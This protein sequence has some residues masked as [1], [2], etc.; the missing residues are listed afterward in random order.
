MTEA[1]LVPAHNAER[2][3]VMIARPAVF[4]EMTT[5]NLFAESAIMKLPMKMTDHLTPCLNQNRL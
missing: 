4:S 5:I 1:R 2:V 3:Y